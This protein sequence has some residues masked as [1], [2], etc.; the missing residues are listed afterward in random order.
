MRGSIH[1]A[2]PHLKLW[3]YSKDYPNGMWVDFEKFERLQQQATASQLYRKRLFEQHKNQMT[4]GDVHPVENL[5]FWQYAPGCKNGELWL[6]PERFAEKQ[7]QIR[8]YRL[9][10]KD[11]YRAAKKRFL[12]R[13]AERLREVNRGYNR[14]ARERRPNYEKERAASDPVFRLSRR[15]RARIR[16][17]LRDGRIKKSKKAV[18]TIGCGWGDLRVHLES[19]F[20]E[21]MSWDNMELW[22]VDHIVPLALAKTEDD[23]MRL[24]HYSNLQPLWA[25]DNLRKGSKTNP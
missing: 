22:H 25:S 2:N 7:K 5:I 8:E 11:A 14:L 18:E 16:E 21:G 3:R 23:V 17:A 13:H 9:K 20:S 15:I 19:L 24:C 1:P 10:N 4:R 12:I 6:T